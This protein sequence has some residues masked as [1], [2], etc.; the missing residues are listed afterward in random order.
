[1]I[2]LQELRELA[3]KGLTNEEI[4]EQTGMHPKMVGEQLRNYRRKAGVH[5]VINRERDDEIIRLRCEELLTLQEIADKF[6]IS[7]ERVRQI[8][9]PYDRDVGD[10]IRQKKYDEILAV[11][12]YLPLRD[13]MEITGRSSGLVYDAWKSAGITALDRR[14]AAFYQNV[15][16]DPGGCHIWTGYLHPVTGYGIFSCRGFKR[17]DRYAHRLAWQFAGNEIPPGMHVLHKCDNPACVNVEHLFLGTHQ[18]NMKDRD[19]KGRTARGERSGNNKITKRQVIMARNLM[20]EH[21]DWSIHDLYKH[22]NVNVHENTLYDAVTGRSWA[23][24]PGAVGNLR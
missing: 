14:K 5:L 11:P 16:K 8:T 2:N 24:L 7:R 9:E 12:L 1:M 22:M 18:D 3:R 6:N 15:E 23:H 13:V 4:A 17:D 20:Y 19:E 10:K 21:P